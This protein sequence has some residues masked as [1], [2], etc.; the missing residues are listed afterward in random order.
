M[1]RIAFVILTSLF[2]LAG[3]TKDVEYYKNHTDEAQEK[4]VECAE[5][6]KSD[7]ECKAAAEALGRSMME[8]AGKMFS[9]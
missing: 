1:K 2:L 6:G 9:Q 3:C 4:L 7:E 5:Q 8:G